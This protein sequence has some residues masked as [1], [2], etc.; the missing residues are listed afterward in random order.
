MKIYAVTDGDYSD[1]HIIALTVNKEC[2]ED[3]AK[4]YR[5]NIEEYEDAQEPLWK[6]YILS[7]QCWQADE[8]IYPASEKIYD[9][10]VYVRA[11]DEAHARKKAQDMVAQYK[12][13]K[14]G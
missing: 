11:E 7:G 14:E 9:D 5:A 6:Y 2:A 3:F 13:E 10:V 8:L 1:H 12:A 4:T